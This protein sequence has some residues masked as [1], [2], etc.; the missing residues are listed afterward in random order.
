M[1]EECIVCKAPLI[2]L[3]QDEWMECELCHKKRIEQDQMPERAL[4][5]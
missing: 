5:L 3:K 1:Q 2:Y 4:C